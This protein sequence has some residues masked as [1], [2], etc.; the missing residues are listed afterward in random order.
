MLGRRKR[1]GQEFQIEISEPAIEDEASMDVTKVTEMA[2][3]LTKASET[4]VEVTYLH[5]NQKQCP[6]RR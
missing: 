5:K 4:F 6:A 3:A 2:T 1:S